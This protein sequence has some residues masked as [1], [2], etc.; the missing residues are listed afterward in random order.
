M[1]RALSQRGNTCIDNRGLTMTPQ[2]VPYSEWSSRLD[3]FSRTHHGQ[4]VKIDTFQP[5]RGIEHDLVDVP[6]LGLSLETHR[7][8]PV[9]IL[10]AGEA[11]KGVFDRWIDDAVEIQIGEWNNGASGALEIVSADERITRVSVGP[12]EETLAPGLVTDG[13]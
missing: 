9:V 7:G 4:E 11:D 13:Q 5:E 12:A 6:L 1:Q 3:Q 2:K 8:W 10:E